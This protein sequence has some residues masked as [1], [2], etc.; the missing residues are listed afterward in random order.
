MPRRQVG[1]AMAD[2]SSQ[3][4]LI[5]RAVRGDRTALG[6][7]LLDQYGRLSRHVAP[8]LAGRLA[9]RVGVDDIVQ[10][11]FRQAIRA[12]ESCQARTGRSFSAWLNT[13]ADR[14]L[15][16]ALKKL[17][18]KKRGGDRVEA[19][20][21][22][23]DPFGSMANLV[24]MLSDGRRSPSQS[25]ARREAVAAMQAGI[26]ALPDDQRQ[27]VRLHH[28]SGKSVVETATMMDRTPGAVRG[29]LRRA[30]EAL[31]EALVRATLWLSTK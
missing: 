6:L 16:D 9:G 23:A 29:L 14:C 10:E 28:L 18:R 21:P 11:T 13:I 1:V 8:K 31:R 22:A 19:R 26:A 15:L 20:A 30:N 7:V 12:I 5:A 3:Q 4:D 25:A 27:A 17:N 2:S 24:E